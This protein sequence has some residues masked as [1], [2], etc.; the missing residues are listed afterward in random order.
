MRRTARG[1]AAHF[2]NGLALFTEAK[3]PDIKRLAA[4][5]VFRVYFFA[6]D[7]AGL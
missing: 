6:L 4:S 2:D 5:R 1:T 3:D 7:T